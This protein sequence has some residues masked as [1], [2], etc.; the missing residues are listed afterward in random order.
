M[1][2]L[3]PLFSHPEEDVVMTCASNENECAHAYWTMLSVAGCYTD[4]N[5]NG[6]SPGITWTSSGNMT[7]ESCN[8]G[9]AELGYSLSGVTNGYRECLV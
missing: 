8:Y 3:T 1:V 2:I 6:L 5:S 7:V 9:C 4:P